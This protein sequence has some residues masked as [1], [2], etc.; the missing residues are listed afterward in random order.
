M[1]SEKYVLGHFYYGQFVREN[2]PAGD[3]RLLARSKGLSDGQVAEALQL[4]LIPPVPGAKK[5]SWAIMRG[6]R[7]VPYALV[8]AEV[9]SAGQPMLHYVLLT[10]EF[11]RPVGGNMNTL[12][13]LFAEDIPT[14]ES[15]GNTLNP[16]V[17]KNV[18]P[19]D[20]ARQIDS[21]LDLMTFTHNRLNSIE[22]LLSTI[23]QGKSVSIINS[24]TAFDERVVFIEGLL[25]LLPAS[26]RYVVTFAT[27]LL[28]STKVDVQLRFLPG[29]EPPQTDGLVFDWQSGQISG[30][31]QDHDYARFITSQ[32]RLDTDLVLQQTGK[33]TG[34]AAWRVK[35]GDRLADSLAYASNRISVDDAVTN[36]QPVEAASVSRILA[37]DPT[38]DD[39]MRVAYARHLMSFSLALGELEHA[40]PIGI[41]L[42]Q[43]RELEASAQR[44]LRDSLSQGHAE[45]V[46]ELVSNWV[47]DPLGP[48]SDGWIDLVRQAAVAS[49]E[50]IVSDGDTDEVRDFLSDVH[51]RGPAIHA[52]QFAGKLVD[53]AMPLA[54]LD[55]VLAKSVFS[56]AVAYLS[57]EALASLLSSKGYV[58]RLPKPLQAYFEALER[59]TPAKSPNLLLEAARA[60]DGSEQLTV[61]M[62]LAEIALARRRLDLIDT[63][64]LAALVRVGV[65][66]DSAN[67]AS[68]R[69]I[70]RALS[71]E[72]Q[73]RRLGPN[74]SRYLLAIL[75]VTGAYED[76]AQQM[77]VQ[78]R[79]L[80]PGER[81]ANYA[82]MIQKLFAETPIS[83]EQI[84]NALSTLHAKG[85]RSLPLAMAYIGVLAGAKSQTEV[86][87]AVAG[88]VTDILVKDLSV[89]GV[90]PLGA[91][92][93][94]LD[95][96]IKQRHTAN[97]VQ[98]ARVLP[99][100][101]ARYGER[102]VRMVAR[103]FKQMRWDADV[104]EAGMEMLRRYIRMS[105]RA[106]A[107]RA[108]K[109]L[110]K[111]L[112]E[113]VQVA[114][115][116][117][118]VLKCLM[119]D[120][121]VLE[122]ADLLHEVADFLEDTAAA[123][124]SRSVPSQGALQNDLD[125]MPGGL[126]SQDKRAIAAEITQAGQAIYN[127][128]ER[129]RKVRNFDDDNRINDLLNGR[130]DPESALEVMRVISGY[131]SQGRRFRVQFEDQQ[132]PHPLPKRTGP[133]LL[134]EV[135]TVH[136]LM[137][138]T[139][140]ALDENETPPKAAAI[141][142]EVDSLWST[143]SLADQ[144]DIV[145]DLA[146]DLQR[147]VEIAPL[148]SQKG[149]IRALEDT[150]L[151]RRLESHRTK[152][153]NTIE[154][155]RFVAGY[156]L[157]RA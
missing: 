134:Q 146:V 154:F 121:G 73:M 147:V 144:R 125:S 79:V 44:Q 88:D 130:M 103:S 131:L 112:G 48:D 18:A 83:S 40:Q 36:S 126:Q 13:S 72:R 54:V 41:L 114:L 5:A 93:S 3:L 11:L 150:N 67:A 78:S 61:A 51:H 27:H 118:Y 52:E 104:R 68:L 46:Y 70:V 62:R 2:Q 138:G 65:S 132:H 89:S 8:N 82:R 108:V 137:S 58:K 113:K 152:P 116:A 100:V 85:I 1:A 84:P 111:L 90:V 29:E 4:G 115:E 141:H 26:V 97:T 34:V 86:T 92:A 106:S 45:G 81:Q 22:V 119:D 35:R 139:L 99:G 117:T 128:G 21:I 107:R 110:G 140:I 59:N 157:Q 66:G 24:P 94:V 55:E 31:S 102:S 19:P 80:Y 91:V 153:R 47:S 60:F 87:D 10:P 39:A 32:L 98:I 95:Y 75:L 42:R 96:H 28:P 15:A 76:L 16:L 57:S 155:Y 133:S 120:H 23:I 142:A 124:E 63:G 122:Y 69:R 143:I 77:I 109:L 64:A 37:S 136:Y 43:D 74:G 148:L 14:Y 151:G 20:K 6:R 30:D 12:R 101:A 17:L 53:I 149:D 25:S 135:E 129:Q 50:A 71:E 33:L 105:E 38:L 127:L 7:E 49:M 9:G 156:Y 145:R 123:F 56:V